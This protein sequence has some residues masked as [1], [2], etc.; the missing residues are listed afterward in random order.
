[1]EVGILLAAI[2]VLPRLVQPAGVPGFALEDIV[3][4]KGGALRTP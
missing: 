4:V 3:E 2:L 1:M